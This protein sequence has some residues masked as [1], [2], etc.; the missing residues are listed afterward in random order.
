MIFSSIP[1]EKEGIPAMGGLEKISGEFAIVIDAAERRARELLA[2]AAKYEDLGNKERAQV[3]G[4]PRAGHNGV[5]Y[6][7]GHDRI[8]KA[9]YEEHY[10]PLRKAIDTVKAA[11]VAL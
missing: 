4:N 10:K 9:T 7:T 8:A 1:I 3:Y 6:E 5:V 2:E 11:G